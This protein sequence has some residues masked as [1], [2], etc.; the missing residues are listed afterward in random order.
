MVGRGGPPQ[1]LN[2]HPGLVGDVLPGAARWYRDHASHGFWPRPQHCSRST[3]LVAG[4]LRENLPAAAGWESGAVRVGG[5]AAGRRLELPYRPLGHHA[6]EG[7]GLGDRPCRHR[8][9]PG[10]PTW[11]ATHPAS[12][13][14]IAAGPAG[15]PPRPAPATS[16][17]IRIGY[18]RTSTVRQELASQF[19]ALERALH[20]GVLL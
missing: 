13:P 15:T 16:M 18:A 9:R 3:L 8:Q 6:T 12:S 19:A 1:G 10:G 17:P 4:V 20:P 7:I 2:G 11:P 5:T 14:S